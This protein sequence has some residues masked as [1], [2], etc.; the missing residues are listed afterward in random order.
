MIWKAIGNL[1]R[2]GELPL[3]IKLKPNSSQ[4][5]TYVLLV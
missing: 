3:S 4:Y 2:I 5:A 1:Q